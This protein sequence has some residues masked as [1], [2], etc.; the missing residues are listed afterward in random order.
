MAKA[1]ECNSHAMSYL[2]P[3]VVLVRIDQQ[4]GGFASSDCGYWTEI[5]L[6]KLCSVSSRWTRSSMICGVLQVLAST[7]MHKA[8]HYSTWVNSLHGCMRESRLPQVALVLQW[9][10]ILPRCPTEQGPGS[11]QQTGVSGSS[12][13]LSREPIQAFYQ[14]KVDDVVQ[15]QEKALAAADIPRK[16]LA[17]N[18][19]LT[20]GSRGHAAIQHTVLVCPQMLTLP[21]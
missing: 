2:L 13:P 14:S 18:H 8:G 15:Q 6:N 4:M 1:S 19:G 11:S 17:G 7:Y 9:T 3:P 21:P 10:K 5:Q 16:K 20:E 12:P